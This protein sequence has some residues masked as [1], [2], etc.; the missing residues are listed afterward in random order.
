MAASAVSTGTAGQCPTTLVAMGLG[1][2]NDPLIKSTI[3]QVRMWIWLMEHDQEN[4]RTARA[5]WRLKLLRRGKSREPQAW[6]CATAR[7]GKVNSALH[8]KKRRGLLMSE[9]ES[10]CVEL[11]DEC[12]LTTSR[13][14]RRLTKQRRR[15]R[16]WGIGTVSRRRAPTR[17]KNLWGLTVLGA[18]IGSTERQ[19]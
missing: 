4:I 7:G 6:T 12:A 3:D 5:W 10:R 8:W 16:G 1:E 13:C 19:E 2:D 18:F 9:L 11:S 15:G 14:S 17:E